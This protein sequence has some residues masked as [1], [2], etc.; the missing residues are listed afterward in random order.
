MFYDGWRNEVMWF[1]TIWAEDGFEMIAVRSDTSAARNALNRTVA[2]ALVKM[3]AMLIM[4]S[5]NVANF[6]FP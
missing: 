1:P 5:W 4:L 3:S 2:S 6:D